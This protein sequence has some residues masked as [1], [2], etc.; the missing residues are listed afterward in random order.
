M[1]LES[2]LN[3]LRTLPISGF[4]TDSRKVSPGDIFVCNEGLNHDSHNFAH[5]A[6]VRGA[7]GLITT[8]TV[9]ALL[10]KQRSSC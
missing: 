3:S 10:P 8:R 9:S 5:E 6:I 4:E 7:I 1:L 2:T